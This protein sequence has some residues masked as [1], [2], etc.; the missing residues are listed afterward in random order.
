MRAKFTCLPSS[1][2]DAG[3][4]RSFFY[5]ITEK[6]GHIYEHGCQ[7]TGKKREG[8]RERKRSG[9]S[10]KIAVLPRGEEKSEQDG[11]IAFHRLH[12]IHGELGPLHCTGDLIQLS[13]ES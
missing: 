1:R 2:S 5:P 13:Q 9:G 10:E 11:L 12:V 7:A 8:H 4:D 3:I 6:W